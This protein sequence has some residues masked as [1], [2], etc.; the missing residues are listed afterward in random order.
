[1]DTNGKIKGLIDLNATCSKM[2]GRAMRILK[3][4]GKEALIDYLNELVTSKD[5]K[6]EVIPRVK[7]LLDVH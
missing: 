7:G 4:R 5:L 6:K 1:M 2:A 3:Q